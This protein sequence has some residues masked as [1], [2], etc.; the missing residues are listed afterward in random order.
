[1]KAF[2]Q[3]NLKDMLLHAHNIKSDAA[4]IGAMQLRDI[5]QL[6]EFDAQ[7]S[8]LTE[9]RIQSMSLCFD[10]TEI[11]IQKLLTTLKSNL[12]E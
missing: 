5:S 10:Q 12:H 6:V 4:A 7:K 1:M 3:N 9:K 2:E 11:E 8:K